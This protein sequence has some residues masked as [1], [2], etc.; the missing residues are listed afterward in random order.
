M[1]RV[2]PKSD[3]AISNDNWIQYAKQYNWSH[4]NVPMPDNV[5]QTLALLDSWK[6]P[7]LLTSAV[8]VIEA[9]VLS[10]YKSQ[11]S[12]NKE[13][14]I[15]SHVSQKYVEYFYPDSF[16]SC[17]RISGQFKDIM[18]LVPIDLDYLS[19]PLFKGT[20]QFPGTLYLYVVR[21]SNLESLF[22]IL[23]KSSSPVDSKLKSCR[24][25]AIFRYP[26]LPHLWC[27]DAHFS[28]TFDEEYNIMNI[29]QQT[30]ALLK[31]IQVKRAEYKTLNCWILDLQNFYSTI[32][33][34]TISWLLGS[35]R[36]SQFGRKHKD[37]VWMEMID[38]AIRKCKGGR[39]YGIPTGSMIFHDIAESYLSLLDVQIIDNLKERFPSR[40]ETFKIIRRS[41]NY[42]VYFDQID[43]QSVLNEIVDT[44]AEYELCINPFKLFKHAP[45]LHSFNGDSDLLALSQLNKTCSPVELVNLA[46]S[47]LDTIPW[48]LEW[49][50]FHLNPSKQVAFAGNFMSTFKNILIYSKNSVQR[51]CFIWYLCQCRIYNM[52][53]Y[54]DRDKDVLDL[55]LKNMANKN[56][57][58]SIFHSTLN[59]FYSGL[60]I[61]RVILKN[62][63]RAH[64]FQSC[65][66]FCVL[67]YDENI[68]EL[69]RK[70][71]FKLVP[72]EEDAE[73]G[74]ILDAN[75][76]KMEEIIQRLG[77]FK[78]TNMTH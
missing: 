58:L 28:I 20:L 1:K 38:T 12:D 13:F 67:N 55:D 51:M 15:E 77:K 21:K 78:I 53:H 72:L 5:E 17:F 60:K 11:L 46:K 18:E 42:E 3:S 32:Y 33:S 27:K 71:M 68:K 39:S 56:D 10:Y 4:I 29:V 52:D 24:Q 74:C 6:D 61:K 47:S 70:V 73:D 57:G 30:T 25:D 66:S 34:H 7:F 59:D 35:S 26:R 63:F 41:D 16:P 19:F 65:I 40:A 44:L 37:S 54:L 14:Q 31:S 36:Q 8:P 50:A 62:E 76:L 43:F 23:S 64:S 45:Y 48:L 22:K 69:Q 9:I 2:L 75:G 49:A